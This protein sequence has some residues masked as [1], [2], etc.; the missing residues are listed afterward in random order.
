M[1]EN[2]AIRD[3]YGAAL[4]ELGEQNK[5]IVGL[6]RMW[7]PPQRAVFLERHFRNDILMWESASWIWCPCQPGLPG[8]G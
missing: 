2:I 6:G 7:L 1:G 8:R 3:A 4:K 5:K